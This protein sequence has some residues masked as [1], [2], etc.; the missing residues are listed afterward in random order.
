MGKGYRHAERGVRLAGRFPRGC[1]NSLCLYPGWHAFGSLKTSPSGITLATQIATAIFT[2]AGG[3][4]MI[5]MESD[6]WSIKECQPGCGARALG[7]HISIDLYRKADKEGCGW[8]P[9]WRCFRTSCACESRS[10]IGLKSVETCATLRLFQTEKRN[11]NTELI[12]AQ[13]FIERL[14]SNRQAYQND[15]YAMYSSLLGGIITDP[16]LMLLPLDDHVVHRGDGVFESVKCVQGRLYNLPSHLDRLFQS[17]ASLNMAVP[18]SRE[19]LTEQ[20]IDTIRAGGHR[21]CCVRILVTRGPGGLG[22]NPYEC[23]ASQVYVMAYRLG[24]WFMEKHPEGARV[25]V[26]A[27]PP[28]NSF[29]AK[30]KSCNYLPNVLM[31]REAVDRGVDFVAA[32]DEQGFLTE[33]ATENIG[34]VSPDGALLVPGMD[35]ILA[36]T[37]MLRILHL[38]EQLV[39]DGTLRG[40]HHANITVEQMHGAREVL[41]FGTTRDV[42]AVTEFDGRPVA[43]GR[44][45]P[46]YRRLVPLLQRDILENATMQTVVPF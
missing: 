34:M 9:A 35:R 6:E 14:Q 13:D 12:R 26:S 21:D 42:I 46:V 17:A 25:G 19:A 2:K 32:F 31:A 39:T 37:T 40:I 10:E 15:Y 29:F 41:I 1:L 8:R 43:E 24:A 5:R 7:G 33:C 38:A 16:A 3:H 30:V 22:A 44:P 27:V 28:K 4:Q 36:G 20:V 11:M 45:G 23:P 18:E